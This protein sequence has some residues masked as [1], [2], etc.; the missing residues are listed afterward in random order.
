MKY[1]KLFFGAVVLFMFMNVNDF[2]SQ[3]TR[4][5]DNKGTISTVNNNN[6]TTSNTAPTS[7]VENDIWFH[8]STTD[9]TIVKVF[10]GT[11]WRDITEAFSVNQAMILNTTTSKVLPH[12]TNTFYNLPVGNIASEVMFN[13]T[14]FFQIISNGKIEIQKSGLYLIS[15]EISV[16]N[17]PSGNTKYILALF[18]NNARRGYLSRGVATLPSTDFWG[19][20]GVI[21]Y[22]LNAGDIIDIRY[23]LNAGTSTVNSN[24]L[25]IGIKKV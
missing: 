2:F 1:N 23:V 19:T 18:I 5:I 22:R 17:M 14:N 7:P 12:T 8:T 10:D 9:P 4:V 24:F 11:I 6:V 15:G 21:M 20:T 13:N 3:E 25:N 16:T